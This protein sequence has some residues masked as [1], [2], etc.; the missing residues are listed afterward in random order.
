MASNETSSS[1]RNAPERRPYEPPRVEETGVFER[2]QLA[3]S[4]SDSTC[5]PIDT[6]S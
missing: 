6:Y 5:G 1:Q 2:L 3:C 4:R